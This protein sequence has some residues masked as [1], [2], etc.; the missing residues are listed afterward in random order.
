V[1]ELKIRNIKF[2][3][4][5]LKQERSFKVLK[6]M[7]LEEHVDKIKK[8][9]EKHTHTHTPFPHIF[10]DI[11]LPMFGTSGSEALLLNMFYVEVKPKYNKNIYKV[12]NLH[13]KM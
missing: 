5:K 8:D 1:K 2:H 13:N 10:T 9:I 7:P 6:H 4:Y 3:T 12:R 11:H